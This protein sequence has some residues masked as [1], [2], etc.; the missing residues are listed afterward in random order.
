MYI[1]KTLIQLSYSLN[2]RLLE[3]GFI[4]EILNEGNMD[5]I[6]LLV[7]TWLEDEYSFVSARRLTKDDA[8]IITTDDN[9]TLFRGRSLHISEIPG[10]SIRVWICHE[11]TE[12]H[13]CGDMFCDESCKNTR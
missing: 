2:G 5:H 12:P 8:F 11:I 9:S 1:N 6:D 4:S 10:Y 13:E 3:P 7:E